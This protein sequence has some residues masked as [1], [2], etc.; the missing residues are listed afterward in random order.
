[1]CA[2]TTEV[3]VNVYNN[4]KVICDS[5]AT[6]TQNATTSGKLMGKTRRHVLHGNED[7]P[8]IETMSTCAGLA[9]G[10]LKLGDEIHI[11]ASYDF[12]KHMGMTSN[13]GGYAEIMGIAILYVAV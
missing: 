4:K 5:Q 11:D 7:I 1:M 10:P 12:A 13:R 8:H 2:N 6:Y 9:L 3:N